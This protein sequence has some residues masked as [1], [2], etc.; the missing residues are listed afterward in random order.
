MSR[1]VASFIA[2]A[3]VLV[4]ASCDDE[5]QKEAVSPVAPAPV[6]SPVAALMEAPV[7]VKGSS[8][9]SAYQRERSKLLGELAKAPEDKALLK[10]ASALAAVITDACN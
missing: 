10:R 4:F 7:K 5:P 3:I 2:S 6:V 8:V 1:R 9:C